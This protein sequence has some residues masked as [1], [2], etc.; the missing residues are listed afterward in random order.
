[1][2]NEKRRPKS[3]LMK[4]HVDTMTR[5][6]DSHGAG[7]YERI[8]VLN[9]MVELTLRVLKTEQRSIDHPMSET[10]G[11]FVNSIPDFRYLHESNE[12]HP[13]FERRLV[14]L[15]DAHPLGVMEYNHLLYRSTESCVERLCHLKQKSRHLYT[16][17]PD[18]EY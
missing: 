10:P 3:A 15:N 14:E 6:V 18:F 7:A 12:W 8:D 13:A 2:S 16:V 9:M 5:I 4:L 11:K 17:S 1:M